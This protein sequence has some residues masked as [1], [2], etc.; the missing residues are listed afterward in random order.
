MWGEMKLMGAKNY[1]IFFVDCN[2]NILLTQTIS[3]YAYMCIYMHIIWN[4]IKWFFISSSLLLQMYCFE[5][6]KSKN[7]KIFYTW[8]LWSI[9][10]FGLVLKKTSR[11]PDGIV[12]TPWWLFLILLI[13]KNE[14]CHDVSLVCTTDC[15]FLKFVSFKSL[16]LVTHSSCYDTGPS[17]FS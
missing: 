4:I 3:I 9:F 14:I 8:K 15:W 5:K 13:V 12:T 16:Q 11:W 6:S 17:R 7:E 10:F 1:Y 2:I